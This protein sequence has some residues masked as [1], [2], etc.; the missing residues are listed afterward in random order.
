MQRRHLLTA[1]VGGTL[2]TP[3]CTEAFGADAGPIEIESETGSQGKVFV[4]VVSRGAQLPT[5]TEI[6][7]EHDFGSDER[8]T[9]TLDSP[10]N[11]D[12]RVYLGGPLGS[13]SLTD[14]RH[15]LPPSSS[16]VPEDVTVGITI[17]VDDGERTV[18]ETLTIGE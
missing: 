7:I 5:G 13:G 3:G 6:T 14:F 10:A 16:L 12:T 11:K 9:G 18:S 1:L 15:G 2:G 8:V 17:T 4:Y